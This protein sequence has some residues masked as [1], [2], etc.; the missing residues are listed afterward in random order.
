MARQAGLLGPISVLPERQLQGI[1]IGAD[2][3]CAAGVARA[4]RG[5]LH[6]ARRPW[7][8]LA[9]RFPLRAAAGVSQY[10]ADVFHGAVLHRCATQG[11]GDFS[12][13]LGATV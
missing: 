12:P 7:L 2:A 3:G 6:A 13:T 1:G 5:G 11:H 4:G 8:L 9:L 10:P